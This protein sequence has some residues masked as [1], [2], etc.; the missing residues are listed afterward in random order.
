MADET[1]LDDEA[2]IVRTAAGDAAAVSAFYDRW[3]PQF[4]RLATRLTGSAHAGEDLAQEAAV[5]VIVSAGLYKKGRSA[6]SWL[7][8]IVYNLSRD[9]WRKKAVREA[10]SL[11]EP[12]GADE[13]GP[14][15]AEVAGREPSAEERAEARERS[16]AVTLALKKLTPTEREVI[17]ARDYEGLSAPEAA[18]VLGISVEK[19]GSR[20]F[21]ARKRL[22]ALLQNDWPGLFPSHE[23]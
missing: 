10:L 8:A 9:W 4:V 12:V 2:L 5:R 16:A 22:G 6:R 11:D 21:R 20:L 17:L 14:R 7:L 19:V 18:L 13:G 3:F 23:L 15:A 1:L